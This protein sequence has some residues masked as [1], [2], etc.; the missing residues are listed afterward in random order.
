[1]VNKLNIK[2]EMRAI[3][4]RD[5]EWWDKLTDE[6]QTALGK[7]MWTQMRWT[8]SVEDNMSDVILL[9]NYYT[10]VHFNTLRHHPKLQHRLLQLAGVG[11]PIRREWVAPSKRGLK[12]K[13]QEWLS[14]QYPQYN[15]DEIELLATTNNKEDLVDYMEQ[16][17]MTPKEIKELFK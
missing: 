13:L 4:C 16:Q 15:D 5:F 2:E 3:D 17:G 14:I 11:V 6:E 12:N 7:Q 9:V 1:M 8:S 10:N